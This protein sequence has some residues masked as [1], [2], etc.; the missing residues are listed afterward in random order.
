M[1]TNLIAGRLS[2]SAP[3]RTRLSASRI[4]VRQIEACIQKC[5]DSG[6]ETTFAIR[7][8]LALTDGLRQVRLVY[9]TLSDPGMSKL[10]VAER[11][12]HGGHSILL[13]DMEQGFTGSLGDLLPD[14]SHRADACTC[15]VKIKDSPVLYLNRAAPVES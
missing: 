3:E 13:R 11:V 12:A 5:T 15:F 6:L 7:A 9:F 10:Q 4:F 1:N 14:F 8:C 2:I